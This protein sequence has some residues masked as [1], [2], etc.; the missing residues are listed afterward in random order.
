MKLESMF[1]RETTIQHYGKRGI[2]WHGIC[3]IYRDPHSNELRMRYM[4]Q[5]I[6]NDSKQDPA[7]VLSLMEHELLQIMVDHPHVKV[8]SFQTDNA[9]THQNRFLPVFLCDISVSTRVKTVRFIHTETQDGKSLVDAHFATAMRHLIDYVRRKSIVSCA[10]ETV[11]GLSSAGGVPNSSAHLVAL[12]RERLNELRKIYEDAKPILAGVLP[13]WNEIV[14][15]NSEDLYDS[16]A[17]L[18]EYSG[19]VPL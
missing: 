1:P 3:I 7:A 2:S 8:A 16:E 17:L 15:V 6:H 19:L 4:D 9:T 11:E 18:Y 14:F 10:S 13:R 12:N 5:L